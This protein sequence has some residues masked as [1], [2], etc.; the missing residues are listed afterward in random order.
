[1]GPKSPI[2]SNPLK[3]RTFYSWKTQSRASKVAKPERQRKFSKIRT[4]FKEPTD[5]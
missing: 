1:M 4:V 2:F 5:R 3:V